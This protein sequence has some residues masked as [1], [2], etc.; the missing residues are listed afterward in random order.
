MFVQVGAWKSLEELENSLILHELFLLYRACG[1][2]YTKS[3]KASAVAFGG[4]VDF[5]DDWYEGTD[6]EENLIDSTNVGDIPIN[7]GFGFE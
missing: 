7:L 5:N 6:I 1:N 3:I 2:E 4:E